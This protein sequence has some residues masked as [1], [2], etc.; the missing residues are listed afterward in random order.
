VGVPRTQDK[1]FTALGGLKAYFTAHPDMEVS[2]PKV[3]VTAALANTLHTALSNARNGVDNAQSNSANK[4]IARDAALAA[5]RRRF[6]GTINELEDLLGDD[7]P[8]WYDFGLSR[9]SDPA[10]PGA[11]LNVVVTALGGG[12]LLVQTAGARRANSFNYYRKIVGTDA[13]PVQ[14]TNTEGKQWTIEGLPVGATVEVTVSGVNDA[15][16]GPASE[17]ISVVVT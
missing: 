10:Q 1:R 8:K 9:P 3:T 2:T 5:F 4:M 11:P 17:P 15:G 16:E 13:E 14:V 7:D 12:R 6:R